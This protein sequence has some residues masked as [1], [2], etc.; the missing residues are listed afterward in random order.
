MLLKGPSA[1]Q[2]SVPSGQLCEDTLSVQGTILRGVLH[3]GAVITV[4]ELLT[5][6]QV[7]IF[8]IVEIYRTVT[9]NAASG[10]GQCHA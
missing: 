1:I 2:V 10:T 5:S 3:Q 4:P 8:G 6:S 7:F 9:S